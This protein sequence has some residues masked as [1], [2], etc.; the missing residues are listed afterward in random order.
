MLISLIHLTR[1]ALHNPDNA[2]PCHFWYVPKKLTATLDISIYR[3][4][5]LSSLLQSNWDSYK[6]LSMSDYRTFL[7]ANI[8]SE[9]KVVSSQISLCPCGNTYTLKVTYRLLSR[10][11][12]VDVN[13]AKKPVHYFPSPIAAAD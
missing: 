1:D 8:L 6:S 10:A 12:K 4:L 9:E 13:K 2:L 7:A 11:L 3:L 5:V